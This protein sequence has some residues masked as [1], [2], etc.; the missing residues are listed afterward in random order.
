MDNPDPIHTALELLQTGLVP[1][2]TS[3]GNDYLVIPVTAQ[4][5][6]LEKLQKHPRRIK[7]SVRFARVDSFCEYVNEFKGK[8]TKVFMNGKTGEVLAEL[9]YHQADEPS[10]KS[11]TA[12]FAPAFTEPWL[13]WRGIHNQA[14]NQREF[15]TFVEDNA[16]D[17][18]NPAP[19]E[20]ID[21]SRNL[22]AMIS[23]NF[24]K[25]VRLENGA[26][27]LQYEETI[28]AKAGQ[29][30]QL[31]VPSLVTL[32]LSVFEGRPQRRVNV[33]LRYTIK[34]GVLNFCCSLMRLQEI[35]QPE[36][37]G[38]AGEIKEETGLV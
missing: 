7:Q 18:V 27:Q 8:G 10:W 25:G 36:I 2:K 17:I 12:A 6:D 14:M 26:E 23:V 30:G 29:R 15:A 4:V 16:L 21:L 11:H 24:K 32:A 20:M 5:Y 13:L 37:D 31:E 28:T 19:A 3:D 33:R 34:E 35:L 1:S 38:L 22:T 9:D